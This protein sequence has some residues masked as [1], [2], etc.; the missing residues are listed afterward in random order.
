MANE[1]GSPDSKYFKSL[2]S[3]SSV[4]ISGVLIFGSIAGFLISSLTAEN[5]KPEVESIIAMCIQTSLVF[6]G[7]FT[8]AAVSVAM[9][10]TSVVFSKYEKRIFNYLAEWAVFIFSIVA[11]IFAFGL[12]FYA[13]FFL[14]LPIWN[15]VGGLV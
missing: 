13:I 4:F 2:M 12:F 10:E 15:K 6:F 11:M 14:V 5:I 8:L 7:S 3:I 9:L 1:T